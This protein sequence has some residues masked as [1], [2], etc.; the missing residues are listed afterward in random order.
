MKKI[1]YA[2][3]IYEC[4]D[5]EIFINDYLQS[6]VSQTDQNFEL[7]ILNDNVGRELVAASI[8]K[9]NF[10]KINVHYRSSR[11]NKSIA[12][13]RKDLITIAYELDA[14]VLIFSDFDETVSCNRVEEVINNIGEYDFAYNDFYVVDSKLNKL[15]SE[16]F[17]SD[18][19]Y[20]D[21]IQDWKEIKSRNYIGL[22]SMSINL[23][24]YQYNNLDFPDNIK[25]VDWFIVTK[26]LLDGGRGLKLCST[27]ANY[28]Q[29]EQ[30]F[31]GIDFKLDKNKLTCG[32]DVKM[33]HYAYFKGYDLAFGLLYTKIQ[34]LTVYIEEVGVN[35]YINTVNSQFDT[36][37]FCW[38]ENIKLIEEI[39]NDIKRT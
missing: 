25:A 23:R 5:F 33:N 28:R 8:E 2:T 16:S 13:L 35:K 15:K 1:I 38:W 17:F 18:K 24:T 20:P 12:Q 6:V 11:K 4:K 34:E 31:V 27:Y 36:S 10:K 32:L 39:E 19:N 9:F 3:V 22:G 14:D 37:Q 7:L 26:V 21:E 30:S 29:H